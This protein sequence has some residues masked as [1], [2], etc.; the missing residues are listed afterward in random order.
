MKHTVA[1]A[2]RILV[3]TW[4]LT[5]TMVA[6]VSVGHPAGIYTASAVAVIW[7]MVVVY[8]S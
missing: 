4:A 8:K 3:V 1:V 7:S 2:V 6:A 5:M